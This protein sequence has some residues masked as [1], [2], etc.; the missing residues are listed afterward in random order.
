MNFSPVALSARM[1]GGGRSS[2]MET[3]ASMELSSIEAEPENDD[4]WAFIDADLSRTNIP[5]RNDN[6][7]NDT[8]MQYQSTAD[9]PGDTK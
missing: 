6:G 4:D 5:E 1:L 7:L 3:E 8:G 2:I 9:E